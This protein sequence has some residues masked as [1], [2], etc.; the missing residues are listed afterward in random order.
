MKLTNKFTLVVVSVLLSTFSLGGIAKA[1]TQVGLG[2]AGS[3]AVL[4]GSAVTNTGSSVITGDLGVSPIN[5]ITGFPPGIVNGTIHAADAASLQAKNDLVTAY[6]NAAGQS[7]DVD[8]T[9]QDLGGL[10]LTPGSYCFDSSAQLTGTLTL[11]AEGNSDAVFLFQIGSALTTASNSSVAL[12]NSAQ[13]CHIFWQV[14]SSATLGTTTDFRGTILALTSITLNNG[15]TATNGRM[16]AR[17]GAVTLDSNVITRPSCSSSTSSSS[18]NDSKRD[19]DIEV[20]KKASPAALTSGP[21]NVTYTYKVSN[22]GNVSLKNISVKDDKCSLVKY[23]SGDRD[24]DLKIDSDES[25]T[26]S[27]TKFVSQTETN[28]VTAKGTNGKEVSDSDKATVVVSTPGFPNA[29]FEP[30]TSFWDIVSQKISTLFS[31]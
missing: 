18:N 16:L 23:I 22:T 5:S 28:I 4:G 11:D 24:D 29:G 26:Y 14:G 13:D 15:A 10:T 21:G 12:I 19:V 1:A 6:N 20:T 8:L 31:F 9:G 3:Y 2:T 7:C 27:C 17:N 25:W 30:V